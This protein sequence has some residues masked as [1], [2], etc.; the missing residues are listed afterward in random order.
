MLTTPHI[1]MTGITGSIGSW[2][3][4]VALMQGASI[5]ALVRAHSLPEAEQRIRHVLHV[6]G[7]ESLFDKVSIILGDLATADPRIR[8]V[9]AV[10]HCAAALD[11]SESA[12]PL[13]QEINVHGT[14]RVAQ[15]AKSWSACLV[16]L[17]TAYVAGA[18]R[19]M[20]LEH[21]S[22]VGQT[23]HNP[24]EQTKCQA[25][26]CLQ[27]W[28]TRT[29]LPLTI[30][31]PGI[32][33]GDSE[34]GRI[35]NFDGLYTLMRFFNTVAPS[36]GARRFRATACAQATKNVVPVDWVAQA[37]WSLL[38]RGRTGTYH[39]THAQPVTMEQLKNWFVEL[40][41]VPGGELVAAGVFDND[42]PTRLE[43]TFHKA[44]AS[45]L[46]YL[47]EE[48]VFDRTHMEQALR[49]RA[50][51]RPIDREFIAT[52]LTA[53]RSAHW[54]K[55]SKTPP[56]PAAPP[57]IVRNYFDNFLDAKRNQQ[58]LPDLRRLTATCRIQLEE[59][60]E[61]AW[62]LDIQNGALVHISNNGCPAAC[63]FTL[64]LSTFR[65]ITA[66]QLAPQKAF[67]D[68]RVEIHGDIETGL[69]L[70][71]VLAAFF[72]LWPYDPLGPNALALQRS[73]RDRL[74]P[75]EHV[76]T[77]LTLA[78]AADELR[79][80]HDDWQ[81]ILRN[82]PLFQNLLLGDQ[83]RHFGVVITLDR[84]KDPSERRR[85]LEQ[86]EVVVKELPHPGMTLYLAGTPVMNAALDRG[87]QK[88]ARTVLPLA[89]A[90]SALILAVVLR[91]V[92]AVI[93]VLCS[94]GITVAWTIG[95]F[96]YAQKPLNMVT[97]VLPSLLFV[98]SMAGGIHMA[99]HYQ[100]TRR[101]YSDKRQALTETLAMTAQPIALSAVTTAVGFVS[102]YLSDMQPVIDFGLFATL[103]MVLSLVTNLTV[104]PTLLYW[105]PNRVPDAN[106]PH[107]WTANWA[108][109]AA[110]HS[111]FTITAAILLFILCA[112]L[113]RYTR[114]EANV[115]KFFGPKAPVRQ[116]YT[117]IAKNL[118]GLYS[119]ELDFKPETLKGK[120]LL[121]VLDQ[122]STELSH[123]PQ[124]AKVI[125]Y[126]TVARV[127]Q[128]LHRP[129]LM[130]MGAGQQT[131]LTQ[132]RRSFIHG[133]GN[134]RC[135][136]ISIWVRSMSAPESKILL[137]RVRQLADTLLGPEGSYDL[138]GVVLLLN[139]AQQSLILTQ[140]KSVA[141]A[142]A[143]VLVMIGLF[144]RSAKAL[145]A[146]I[147]PNLIPILSLFA[148]MV[149]ADIALD[150]ATVMIAGIA[151][152]IG[153][154]DTI[155]FLS[156]YRRNK[157]QEQSISEAI[158]VTFHHI[159]RSITF[160]TVVAITA[161]V[162]MLAAEFRPIQYF[163]ALASLTMVLAWC[164]D[165]WIL[166]ACVTKLKLWETDSTSEQNND[167]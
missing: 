102:L 160:T 32:V 33:V 43:E 147:L 23:F 40:F 150:G 24:Y 26:Q 161:F 87:S 132:F 120:A 34:Q 61:C 149:L 35:V 153:A 110:R 157:F 60:P 14:V 71:T 158:A 151:I 114:V 84:F 59:W 156:H 55:R 3:A 92:G 52:L 16:H 9:D 112:G 76:N 53:A 145:V 117:F 106:L 122:F 166:P 141:L 15:W 137:A 63:T 64:D 50:F 99:A 93:A 119:V 123:S 73:L 10:F 54:G 108:G 6:V 165:V 155:H 48:P 79:R 164:G 94:V 41:D 124:V 127:F 140:L 142:S 146:A 107:H 77:V 46:P 133:Q 104:L 78:D 113:A 5:T 152:G 167:A 72:K 129:A 56:A 36:L 22:N 101:R 86:I 148:V 68:R 42:P 49:E 128:D 20:A 18:R 109:H 4:K 163:G 44:A 81:D 8:N 90:L 58:L 51:I 75:I 118:T 162:I 29:G 85:T 138:T 139:Q 39:L 111:K 45:Y 11:F 69:R 130:N 70:A 116:S 80:T 115:L 91:S 126:G 83:G 19:D 74:Y 31:R 97:V 30:L 67:F 57:G 100:G 144:M 82:E 125:H 47:A 95:L 88:A 89:I 159:G 135:F 105:I 7:A 27:A 25:E 98:L 17:S 66:G 38:Q 103:G 13:L 154:D 143:I 2:I 136:R 28:Q 62:T 65:Q 1:F 131:P 96:V 37:A 134:Q 121:A 12:S 21:E